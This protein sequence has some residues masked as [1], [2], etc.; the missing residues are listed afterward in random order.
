MSLSAHSPALDRLE[1]KLK[2]EVKWI[3]L[4]CHIEFFFHLSGVY[5]YLCTYF[6]HVF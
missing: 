3:K 5:I 4:C 6:P 2:T 1:G